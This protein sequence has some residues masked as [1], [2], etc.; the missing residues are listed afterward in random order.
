MSE[1]APIQTLQHVGSAIQ[2]VCDTIGYNAKI[3]IQHK[4]Y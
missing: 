2:L 1:W 4:Q 3:M